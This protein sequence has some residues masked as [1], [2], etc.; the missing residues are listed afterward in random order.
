MIIASHPDDEILGCGGLLSKL[1]AIKK[2]RVKVL[3]ILKVFK[4]FL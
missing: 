4:D 2:I 1:K 3:F